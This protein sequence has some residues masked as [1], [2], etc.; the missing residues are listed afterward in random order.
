MLDGIRPISRDE[1][2]GRIA[3]LQSYMQQEKLQAVLLDA[4]TSLFYFTGISWSQSERITV[5]VIPSEG[6]VAYVCPAFESDRLK[7]MILFGSDVYTWEEDESPFDQIIMLLRDSGRAEGRIGIDDKARFFLFDGVRQAAPALEWVN[8]DRVIKACRIVKS[9][10]EI[11][12]LQRANEITAEAFKTCIS[13]LKEGM[14]QTEFRELSVAAHKAMGVQ[15]GIGVQFGASTA[16]PHGSKEMTYLKKGDV[17]L[18]DGGCKVEG[19][20]SDISRT[21]VFGTPTARQKEIWNLEK[22][23]QAA[24]LAAA[25]L[26]ATCGDVDA[27]ARKVIEDYGFGPGYKVPGLSH[28]TGHGIGLDGHEWGNI[29]PGNRTPLVP[30]MCFSVEPTISIYGEF[31]VRLE[32]CVYIDETGAHCFTAPSPAIDEPFKT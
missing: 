8:A 10:A 5:A 28:R 1:R 13:M 16:F 9:Q 7:E 27:A 21:I 19:Y 14:S 6:D 31:G 2:Q 20:T 4:T 11:A 15:G 26:G 32:D 12:L 3:R 18:M 25:R 23:A 29:L 22:K 30:G 17:V 24:G